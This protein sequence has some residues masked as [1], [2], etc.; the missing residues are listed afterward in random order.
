VYY[1]YM[2][3]GLFMHQRA[4]AVKNPTRKKE[5]E[6]M[7]IAANT[8]IVGDGSTVLKQAALR[9]GHDGRI[10]EL[11]PREA[12]MSAHPEESLRDYGEATV[13]PG[14]IDMHVH[15]GYWWSKPD[16]R[17][18]NDHLIAYLGMHNAQRSLFA[19]VTTVRDVS[20]PH[21]L[22]QKMREAGQKGY[23]RLPRI[24]HCDSA[25]CFTGGHGWELEGGMYEVDG[26]AEIRKAIRR[27][28]RD[29]AD[30]IKI[31]SSH[32]SDISEYTQA[33]LDAAA[34]ECHRV[35]RKLAVH[36]GTQ[37]SI[38]MSID[39]GIDTIE[40]GT[41]LTVE[42]CLQMREKG[43][44]WVPTI[45]AYTYIY[46]TVTAQIESGTLDADNLVNSGLLRELGYFEK[47]ATTYRINFK[48]LYD[49]G[50]TVV[51]GTDMVMDGAPGAPVARELQY[52]VDYGITPVEAIGTATGN[53]AKALGLEEEIGTL[54]GGTLADLLVVEGDASVDIK[55]LSSI[56]DVYQDGK[57]IHR[58]F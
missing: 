3:P 35:G 39:A 45:I 30:F 2:L 31:M 5:I 27:N 25:L 8:M 13:M 42:Q 37:P 28:L 51:A 18:Y 38:Q 50:V 46:E 44:V 48:K 15:L 14:L 21:M 9:I 49:T 1:D 54:K 29:G 57:A 19:G 47:A 4:A 23:V 43:L 34:D 17:K 22:C 20:S 40:H 58:E 52:F 6:L 10:C 24:I 36:A 55:A 53:S 7:L 41:Y 32:R 33:E 16:N 12:V 56:L 26:E 11:G